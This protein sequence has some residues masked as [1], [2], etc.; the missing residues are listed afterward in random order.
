MQHAAFADLDLS[1]CLYWSFDPSF[2]DLLGPNPTIFQV[3]PNTSTYTYTETPA[4]LPDSNELVF[5]SVEAEWSP[6]IGTSAPN[7]IS[8]LSLTTGKLVTIPVS[9]PPGN[10][11]GASYYKKD[12]KGLVIVAGLGDA[13]DAKNPPAIYLLDPVIG[14]W[15]VLVNNWFGQRF[16]GFDDV[17]AMKDGYGV[18]IACG[19]N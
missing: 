6:D 12:G 4:Y 1:S 15:T 2:E 7:N 13:T 9:P 19:S 16:G 11:G 14:N 18:L 10:L 5:S 8:R 3:G 17:I